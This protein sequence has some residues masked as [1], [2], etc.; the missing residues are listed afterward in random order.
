MFFLKNRE[1]CTT[2]K[3]EVPRSEQRAQLC[4]LV[5]PRT[6]SAGTAQESWEMSQLLNT[7]FDLKKYFEVGREGAGTGLGLH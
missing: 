3:T 5:S 1:Q 6:G 4:G 2:E 7:R